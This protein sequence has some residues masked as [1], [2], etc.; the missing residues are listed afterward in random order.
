M[1]R[2]GDLLAPSF[3]FVR[4][5]GIPIGAHWTWLLVF[6]YTTWSLSAQLL[7]RTYPGLSTGTYWVMGLVTA[8]AF[9]ASVLLHELGHAFTARREGMQISDI[10]LWLFGGV[11][12]FKGMFPSAGAEFRIAIAGPLVSLALA[13]VLGAMAFGARELGIFQAARGVLDFLARI[14]GILFAFNL[15]PA[16]PLDGGRVLRAW[17]WHR[18]ANFAAAT[19]SAARAGRTFGYVLIGIG[20][21]GF[22]TN[23]ATGGL[24]FVFLG[25]FLLQAAASEVGYAVVR[26]AFGDLSVR[27]VM[28]TDPVVVPPGMSVSQFIEQTVG[29]RG[30]STYPVGNGGLSGLVSASMAGGVLPADRDSRTVGEIMLPAASV[31]VVTADTPAMTALEAIREGPGRAV[32]VEDGRIIGMLSNSDVARAMELAPFRAPTEK[33]ARSA[34]V[35][36][37]VVAWTLIALAAAAIY[38]PPL[39]V[40]SPGPTLDVSKD[41]EIE[42]IPTG[43]LNGRYLLVSVRATQPNGLGAIF[44]ILHPSQELIPESALGITDPEEGRRQRA[45]FQESRQFAAAAA[46]EAAG[47]D[48]QVSGEG[49]VITG[50]AEGAPA[51]GKLRVGDVVSAVDGNDVKLAQDLRRIVSARPPGTNFVLSVERDGRLMQVEIATA[52]LREAGSAPVIGV[53]LETRNFE[54]ELPFEVTFSERNIGGP[55]AGLAYALAITDLIDERDLLKGKTIAATGTIQVNGEVGA[56]WGLPQKAEAARNSGADLFLVPVEEIGLVGRQDDTVRGVDNLFD[57]LALLQTA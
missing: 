44:A 11:A 24:W 32:V 47:F 43:K 53:I 38:H 36:V 2:R 26:Q 55:S 28:S 57:A 4:V 37:W 33:R 45:I 41:I 7:P 20:L 5:A 50:I 3:T 15:I 10:T 18:Q 48:V 30:H 31:P 12:R 23:A 6:V 21:L 9:F 29:P 17:L 51:Q 56:V 52:R 16:L 22:F 13:V 49:A 54:M 46:A 27:D 14:N 35:L 8:V 19:F 34:G 25:W 40:I 42:G 1:K 39:I